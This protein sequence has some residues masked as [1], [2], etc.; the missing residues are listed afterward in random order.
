MP[1][2]DILLEPVIV[3]NGV[4]RDVFKFHDLMLKL[5]DLSLVGR[6]LREERRLLIP[7]VDL[8]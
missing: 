6:A 7:D 3:L 5:D 8:R 2:D 1:D 4:F